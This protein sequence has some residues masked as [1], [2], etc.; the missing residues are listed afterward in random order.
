MHI[1]VNKFLQ[2]CV[3]LKNWCTIFLIRLFIAYCPKNMVNKM[4]KIDLEQNVNYR[5]KRTHRIF[6]HKLF[7][8]FTIRA[9]P[10]PT[11]NTLKS[12]ICP[13]VLRY[14]GRGRTRDKIYD[15]QCDWLMV[16]RKKWVRILGWVLLSFHECWCIWDIALLIN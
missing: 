4:S 2:I 7:F 8:S 10:M 16:S 13:A 14:M 1:Y 6:W 12:H 15:L 9:S 5:T 11:I 3:K